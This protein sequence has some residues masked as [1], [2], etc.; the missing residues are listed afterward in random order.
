MKIFIILIFLLS[1]CGED[2]C[3]DSDFVTKQN[4]CVFK[5]GFDVSITTLEKTIT[6]TEDVVIEKSGF[7]RSELQEPYDHVAVHFMIQESDDGFVVS[8]TGR[9]DEFYKIYANFDE[10]LT[11]SSLYHELLHVY[12]IHTENDHSH[13]RTWFLSGTATVEEYKN[14]IEYQIADRLFNNLC[15]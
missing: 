15:R 9:F 6:I 12:L 13:R 8:K 3:D 10:C 14:S 11:Y 1:S 7:L 5:N 2:V 4:I